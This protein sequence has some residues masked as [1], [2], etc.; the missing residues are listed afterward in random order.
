PPEN[1]GE[2][3]TDEP[4]G[5]VDQMDTLV[6]K[7]ASACFGGVGAPFLVVPDTS[8]VAVARSNEHDVATIAL[9][10]NRARL[11]RSRMEAVIKAD[12]DHQPIFACELGHGRELTRGSG[13]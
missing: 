11:P 6:E 7:L 10:Q 2:L 12:F 1:F 5:K 8:P 4:S 3:C 9:L 13:R